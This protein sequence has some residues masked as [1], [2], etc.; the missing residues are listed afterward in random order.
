[1]RENSQVQPLVLEIEN[2][3]F[4]YPTQRG[5]VNCVVNDKTLQM[6]AVP[7]KRSMATEVGKR[8]S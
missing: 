3:F 5:N 7:Q 4:D 2:F 8:G 6:I 1:V